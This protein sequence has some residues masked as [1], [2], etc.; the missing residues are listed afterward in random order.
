MITTVILDLAQQQEGNCE[1]LL[2]LLRTIEHL[3]REIR[4][5][6]F[7][8]SLPNTRKDVYNLLRDIEES[9]GWPYIERM[10]LKDLMV[11]LLSEEGIH[12]Q[13]RSLKNEK[14]TTESPTES[15][16]KMTE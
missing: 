7:E 11:H 15:E 13:A 3:H 9:G 14:S 1:G 16:Q 10:R 5:Q 6:M 12:P 8:P 4:E 2:L